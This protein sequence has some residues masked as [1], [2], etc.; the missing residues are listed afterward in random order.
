[1]TVLKC[2]T[3][4]PALCVLGEGWIAPGAYPKKP[5]SAPLP[6]YA[7]VHQKFAKLGVR[8][9]RCVATEACRGADNGEAFIKPCKKETGLSL[10]IIDGKAEAELAAIGCGSLFNADA[11]TF[12]IVGHW[13]RQHGSQ[14]SQRDKRKTVFSG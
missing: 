11:E 13:R 2:V 5:W 12:I 14:S 8:R 4:L 7:F 6:H 3:A 9:M 1:M 10:E